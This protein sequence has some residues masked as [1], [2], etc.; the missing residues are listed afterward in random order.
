MS[1][2]WLNIVMV[3]VFVLIGGAFS[4]AEIALVSLRESQVRAMGENGGRRGKAVQ[5]LL[6][7]P[8][9]F[10]AAVQVGVTLAG[11][12]SAAFGA[13]TRSRPFAAWLV[14]LGVR[15]GL[16]G[17]L[18]LVLVTIAISYLSLVVGELT[19]K[20]LALQRAEGFSLL[21]AAPLNAIATL[22]RPVIW[23][24]SKSTNV[25]VRLLGGDPAAS[26]ESISQ[27]ELR[28]LV[29]AHE[30]L[31]SDERRL[32]GEVFRAGDREVREVMTPRTEVDFL[33]A[34][35]TA[36]RAAK[37]VS[38]SSHSRYP[39]VGRD[40]DDVLGFVHVRDLFLP[41]H[42][43]GR[44]ATVGD[45]VRDVKRLP[46]TAGVLTALSEMRRENHH[47]AIVV[48]EYGGTD[49][50]VTLEDLIEEVIGE[51]YDEYDEDVAGE[52]EE[53]PDGPHEVDGLLNLDD[54]REVTGLQLPEGPYETVAGYVLAELGRLPVVGDSVE[55]E[56]RTLTVL[57]LDGRRI[58][59]ISVSRASEPEIDP[60]QVPTSTI[61]T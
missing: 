33:D 27:E 12:F 35:M 36:S 58:A 9:R 5:R 28:D 18:A 21:V 38:D 7:D 37:Q 47:L 10:L 20:R 30:S 52:E 15:E 46:G 3:V 60:A 50:I 11:F 49:G 17:T 55:V 1:D 23:L 14:D 44:A 16:A 39:V 34:S 26:G 51:I 29:T 24:L 4:G 19:P 25:L 48:D 61:G 43:A 57:E 13:S 41:N 59:R 2:V 53:R 31:T 8:N 40:E 32:I 6:S 45:L 56:G 42:P 22:S 54:F